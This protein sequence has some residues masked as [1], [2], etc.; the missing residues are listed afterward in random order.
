MQDR[1]L[2]RHPK[3][4][5]VLHLRARTSPLFP[6][7]HPDASANPAVQFV[8]QIELLSQTEVTCPTPN[9]TVQVGHPFWD[10]TA[11][12]FDSELIRDGGFEEPEYTGFVPPA[13]WRFQCPAC[14]ARQPFDF[15]VCWLCGYGA[16]GDDTAYYRRWGD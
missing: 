10:V 4:H 8:K 7:T 2:Q 5:K 11:F 13:D 9:V 15:G 3:S 12:N 14:G 1:H 6:V 16:D